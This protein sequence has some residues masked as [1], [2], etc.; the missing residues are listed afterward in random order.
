VL[1]SEASQDDASERWKAFK[2]CPCC[3]PV[4]RETPDE[5]ESKPRQTLDQSDAI[6]L[7][8]EP[9]LIRR[10]S[11]GRTSA[12]EPTASILRIGVMARV[13]L[14]TMFKGPTAFILGTGAMTPRAAE[15]RSR[16]L[17]LLANHAIQRFTPVAT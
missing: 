2:V 17:F 14:A 3:T 13:T 11:F 4:P 6:R 8:C 10:G 7:G 1:A 5:W 16:R 9:R 12:I 15:L